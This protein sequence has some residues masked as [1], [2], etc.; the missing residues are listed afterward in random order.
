MEMIDS[1][2]NVLRKFSDSVFAY[3]FP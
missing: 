2:K 1:D 3:I